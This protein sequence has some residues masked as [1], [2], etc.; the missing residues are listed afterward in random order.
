MVLRILGGIIGFI[1]IGILVSDYFTARE[2]F[3]SSLVHLPVAVAFLLY[4]IGGQSLLRKIFP[5]LASKDESPP[6]KD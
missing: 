5:R 1:F 6:S 4:A 2:L 3:K